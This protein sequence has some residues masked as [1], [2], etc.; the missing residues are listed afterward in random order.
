MKI[1]FNSYYNDSPATIFYKSGI[2]KI[3]TVV[4][5]DFSNYGDYDYALFMGFDLD[6]KEI[7]RAK[8]KNSGL[9]C[10]V[11][12]PRGD[13]ILN[14]IKFID[15]IV[16]D[17]VEM[18]DYFSKCQVPLFKYYE[19]PLIKLQIKEYLGKQKIII[20][21]HGNKIHL[22]TMYCNVVQALEKLSLKYSIEF[23]AIYNI[24]KTGLW[25]LGIPKNIIVK[26]IQ[27]DNN[28]LSN[29]DKIDI[30]IVPIF[31]PV[32]NKHPIMRSFF[33]FRVLFNHNVKDY[34]Y[35]FK[36]TTGAGRL[37]VFALR[38]IPVI[39]DM[40]PSASEFIKHGENGYLA[41]SS[42]GW[43]N[44]LESLIISKEKRKRFGQAL[45][46]N[47]NSIVKYEIQNEKFI[48]F[49]NNINSTRGNT[50]EFHEQSYSFFTM[51]KGVVSHFLGA[52]ITRIKR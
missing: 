35:R 42:A 13:N 7:L 12:D 3:D 46:S 27:F 49:L 25:K 1:V 5:D 11:I 47:V 36:V 6:L 18:I 40:A 50:V 29:L 2:Q 26:H 21:Y 34:L 38:G 15:F 19:Y 22:M 32:A 45:Q 30:G 39:S 37:I 23:W 51:F 33:S 31:L 8:N 10:G 16:V 43:Y 28:Y 4:I 41:Y 52:L 9:L 44:S 20:G 14:Y 17:S 48:H 24:K